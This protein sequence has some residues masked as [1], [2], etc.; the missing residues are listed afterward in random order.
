MKVYLLMQHYKVP[1]DGDENNDVFGA[2]STIE[3][4]GGYTATHEPGEW[5]EFYV[6]TAELDNPGVWDSTSAPA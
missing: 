3:K 2:F 1:D 6:V 5:S 4:L